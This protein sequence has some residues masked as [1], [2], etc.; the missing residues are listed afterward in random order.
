M[1]L[2]TVRISPAK[3]DDSA[4]AASVTEDDEEEDYMVEQ[5]EDVRIL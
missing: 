5:Y 2:T 1:A 4:A 3:D